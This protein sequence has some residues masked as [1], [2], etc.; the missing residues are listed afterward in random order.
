MVILFGM[1]AGIAMHTC[2]KMSRCAARNSQMLIYSN[3]ELLRGG[4]NIGSLAASTFVLINDPTTQFR[5]ETIFKFEKRTDSE[6][7]FEDKCEIELG[8]G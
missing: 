6:G 4:A 2:C 7:I 3:L 8:I 1:K 5:R